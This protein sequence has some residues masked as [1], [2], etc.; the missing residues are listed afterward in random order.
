[1]NESEAEENARGGM[2]PVLRRGEVLSRRQLME[3]FGVGKETFAKWLAAGLVPLMTW[4]KE[5]FYLTDEVIEILTHR[6]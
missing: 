4:T 5:D 3:S 6:L 1:M 2:Y